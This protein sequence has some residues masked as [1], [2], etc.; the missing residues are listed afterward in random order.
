VPVVKDADWI[1]ETNAGMKASSGCEMVDYVK[2]DICDGLMI[3]YAQD[4]GDTITY[5]HADDLKRAA[6]SLEALH[7]LALKNLQRMLKNIERHDSDGVYYYTAGGTYE[8]SLILFPWMWTKENFGLDDD[9]VFAV[10]T[11]DV[12]FATSSK[13][14]RGMERIRAAIAKIYADKPNYRLTKDLFAIVN[15]KIRRYEVTPIQAP[16]PTALAVTPAAGSPAAPPSGKAG[17]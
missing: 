12:L 2:E 15:G 9:V 14:L 7:S 4:G 16:D 3:L 6:L 10:P 13:N 17:Q 8:A 1:R 11:R 5:L